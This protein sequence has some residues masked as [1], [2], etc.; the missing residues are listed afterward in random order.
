MSGDVGDACDG[1]SF[2]YEA[3][4]T[5]HFPSKERQP[6][7]AS[8]HLSFPLPLHLLVVSKE[9]GPQQLVGMA[10]HHMYMDA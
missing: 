6:P 1:A 10:Q 3:S 8:S 2:G 7:L 5:N 4:F 9:L